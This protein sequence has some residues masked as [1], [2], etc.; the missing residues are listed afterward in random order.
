MLYVHPY[1]GK[2]PILTSIFQLGWNHQL[3]M[4]SMPLTGARLEF[5]IGLPNLARAKMWCFQPQGHTFSCAVGSEL[6]PE[7]VSLRLVQVD[8]FGKTHPCIG[9]FLWISSLFFHFHP[10]PW[11]KCFNLTTVIFFQW[12]WNH[13]LEPYDAQGIVLM[14]E[15]LL[16]RRQ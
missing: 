12:G 9:G 15:V 5:A 6:L 14:P 2:I 4:N 3:V 8:C 7:W 13:Q 11:A 1:L 10:G 16:R